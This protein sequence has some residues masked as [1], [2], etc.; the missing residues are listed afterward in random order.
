MTVLHEL[1]ALENDRLETSKQMINEAV[2]TFTKRTEHFRSEDKTL[3]MKDDARESENIQ[4]TNEVVTTVDEKLNHAWKA[5]KKSIDVT[6]S[7]DMTNTLARAD[8]TINGDVIAKDIPAIV[9]LSLET[10]L[11]RIR[12]MYNTIPTLDPAIDWS[13]DQNSGRAIFKSGKVKTFKTEKSIEIISMAKATKEHP[14]QVQAVN[15]DVVV[16]VY[17]TAKSSGMLTP[18]DKSNLLEKIGILISAVKQARQRANM[19]EVKKIN[20]GETIQQFIHG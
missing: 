14:E 9:L 7:K 2:T 19:Q 16:G 6:A 20:L 5:F 18:R 1:I 4:T 12:G 17:H 13:L 10:T 11:G 8:I 15:K 3:T